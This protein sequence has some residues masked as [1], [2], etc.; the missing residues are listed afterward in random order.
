M[1]INIS[2]DHF[3]IKKSDY[4]YLLKIMKICLIFLFAFTLQLMALNTN[5]QDVIIKLKTN[6][7]TIGQL[8]NEIEKQTDYLIVYSNREVD[9]NRKIN[10][11][12]NSAK[13]SSYLNEAFS[14]TDIG[15]DFENDYIVLSKKAHQNVAAITRLIQAAQ[16]RG[17]TITGKITTEN[18]EP[19]IGAT[20]V[21]KGNPTHGTVTDING[22]F[23][24]TNI[25]E[26]ATLQFTY[27]GMKSQEVAIKGLTTVNIT[28]EPDIELLEEV[29]VVGY[30]TMKKSD[31]TGAITVVNAGKLKDLPVASLDQKIKGQI[32]GVRIQQITGIPGG[33]TSVQ[34]R[35]TGSLGAGNE[36]LYVVDG[37]PY[38]AG[39][40]QN[41]NPLIQINPNNI[42]SITVLKDASSTA[43]YGS[44][45]A[46]GVIIITTKKGNYNQTNV[47][48]SSMLGIATLPQ[49]G[50]PKMMNAREFA[51]FQKE[52]V[53][54]KI[55]TIEQREPTISD[56]PI[57]IANPQELTGG[58]DW[59]GML[60]H[61]AVIQD[62]NI[63]IESGSENSR[64]VLN[65][66][67]Y[68]QEGVMK[69]TGIER[70]NVRLNMDLKLGKKVLIGTSVNP[71]FIDQ[72][73][74][75]TDTGRN[76]IIATSLWLDPISKAYDE[77]GNLTPFIYSYQNKYISTFQGPN[78]LYALKETIENYK[79]FSTLGSGFI[80]WEIISGLKARSE[81][82]AILDYFEYSQFISSSVGGT[83]KEP[84]VG[85]SSAIK[86]TGNSL[87]WLLENTLTYD[88][89]L[90]ENNFL[91]AL[92]GFT[93]Q[94]NRNTGINITAAPFANDLIKTINA[95]QDISNWGESFNEW[96]MISY[97]SRVNYSYK[98]KYLLTGTFRT[99]G[100]SRFGKNNRFA[101][102]PS[103]AAAW[104]ISEEDFL[105]ENKHIS[106]AKLR[107][108][109]G[110]SGNNNIGNYSALANINS[111]SYVI[112][113]EL[114]NASSVGLSNPSLTW[115]ESSQTDIG[116][117]LGFLKERLKINIDYYFR[118]SENMLLNNLIPAITGF[119]QQT[120][121]MGNVRNTGFEL[122]FSGTPIVND[123]TW[124]F[125]LNLAINRNKIIAMNEF[126]DQI[127]SGN[128]F[129][130]PTHISIVGKPIAQFYGLII[131]GIL[132]A[133][134]MNNPSVAKWANSQYAGDY[135]YRD[136]NGDGIINDIEDYA[137]IGNPHPD[138]VYGFSNNFSYKNL[139]LSIIMDGQLGGDVIDG[140]HTETDF[141][142]GRTNVRKEWL[143]R[144]RSPSEPGD[145]KH[146]G[147]QV[148]A[149]GY[150]WK[151]SNLWIEDASF[152]RLSNITLAYTLPEKFVKHSKFINNCRIYT[153]IQNL[154]LFSAYRGS[155][156]EAHFGRFSNT[157]TPGWDNST[158]PLARTTS[159]GIDLS[160]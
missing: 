156:P 60:F 59:Y 154:A 14:N 17:K 125:N 57:Q 113:G 52:V 144:W 56:Y 29:V 70:Y 2:S 129:G 33:G 136:I 112:N 12:Q 142:W 127:L 61:P 111:G 148:Y 139:S 24:L 95:A 150:N 104:R 73:R 15:Y 64:T 58:T 123:F 93:I 71:S 133:E 72:D 126:D 102:F 131:D 62:Y 130:F 13:V 50:Q 108:S 103:F 79:E 9:I 41:V 30:G 135:R 65:L 119:N 34:I 38:S 99:D 105:R 157:L 101:Y 145:G 20:I 88:K 159:F 31:L 155:N 75:N 91:N 66:G 81:F 116:I 115:E 40:N 80:Q 77:Y 11:Q 35:G 141:M 18:E 48:F 55:R 120:V 76:D 152:L 153:T 94:E 69:H 147:V 110:K 19:I 10:F 23:I 143:N 85:N 36:P 28:M 32:P 54:T 22:N 37:M 138:M 51:E 106:N 47:N 44:R 96:S 140:T 1:K 137:I 45:G 151:V 146:N 3:L 74:T 122:G 39:S 114:V 158:Y 124:D 42:E 63:N 160:F 87:N 117:D 21:E 83:Q 53:D 121:N 100:S 84:T 6:N 89:K 128:N 26:N 27:I 86:N 46:N 4:E 132:T 7:V 118:K 90:N 134:D 25:P 82:N 8:I 107:I 97:L 98:N 68:D 149:Q 92:I 16:Q 5:A 78:P 67:Y 43:I 109:Y 49:K